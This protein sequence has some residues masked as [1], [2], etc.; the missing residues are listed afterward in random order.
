M[1]T[2]GLLFVLIVFASFNNRPAKAV[3]AMPAPI[4]SAVGRVVAVTGTASISR[5]NVKK[6]IQV[7]R[8]LPLNTGDKVTVEKSSTVKVVCFANFQSVDLPEG[9]HSDICST[10]QPNDVYTQNINRGRSEIV[11]RE[12]GEVIGRPRANNYPE[13]LAKIID[14]RPEYWVS[15]ISL[16]KLIQDDQRSELVNDIRALPA[17]VSK[18]EKRLLLV[19]VYSMNKKYGRAIEELAAVSN[20]ANDPFIQINLGDLYTASSQSGDAKRAYSAA[21]QAAIDA[22]EP[23]AEAIAQHAFGLL[24]KYEKAR[25]PEAITA[26]T[27][28]ISLYRDLDE[29][30]V[31]DALQ[32]ELNELQAPPSSPPQK[33]ER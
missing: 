7:R 19:D 9:P 21:I 5:N 28:A 10:S 3:D 8:N 30:A 13:F 4:T 18:D 29:T 23:L 26:L 12:N 33:N 1:K 32:S 22:K 14:G 15:S 6:P 20:A 17:N 31:A 11:T 27:R 2:T 24:L 16:K 25:I